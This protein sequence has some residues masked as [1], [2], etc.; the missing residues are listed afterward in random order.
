[1]GID[2]RRQ[3]YPNVAECLT[4][5]LVDCDRKCHSN[6]K[7][8]TTQNKWPV[9]PR[10]AHDDA[11]YE[12]TFSNIVSCDDFR[13]HDTLTQSFNNQPRTITQSY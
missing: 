9:S 10:G 3:I 13:F 8:T 11:R 4:L 5:I 2:R 12:H 1:M 7:L 6:W